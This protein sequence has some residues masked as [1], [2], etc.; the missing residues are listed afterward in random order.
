MLLLT[1]L[2][3]YLVYRL[4]LSRAFDP[5]Y[6]TF[7]FFFLFLLFLLFYVIHHRFK[8]NPYNKIADFPL[9]LPELI[10]A[11][12]LGLFFPFLIFVLLPALLVKI[13]GEFGTLAL[14]VWI[15]LLFPAVFLFLVGGTA[16]ALVIFEEIPAR[17]EQRKKRKIMEKVKSK[18][19]AQWKE[20]LSVA[21]TKKE[22]WSIL[23]DSGVYAGALSTFYKKYSRLPLEETIA[24]AAED[25]FVYRNLEAIST[26]V[27]VEINPEDLA[28]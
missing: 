6:D 23:D 21:K 19:F 9:A 7:C 3:L 17:R 28:K 26:L 27:G 20:K 12:F 1:F 18:Y 2:S 11:I 14:V 25:Y 16:S 15:F 24:R 22:L 10:Y 13:F 5:C 4:I 8:S